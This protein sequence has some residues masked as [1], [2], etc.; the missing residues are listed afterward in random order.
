[1]MLFI[2]LRDKTIDRT[3]DIYKGA[4]YKDNGHFGIFFVIMFHQIVKF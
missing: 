1:M 3:Q 2:S 4:Y